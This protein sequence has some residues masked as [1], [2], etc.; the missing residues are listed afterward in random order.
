MFSCFRR[1]SKAG[2]L[3]LG[4]IGYIL[5]IYTIMWEG[6]KR[7]LGGDDSNTF[8]ID[9]VWPSRTCR[10][11][12]LGEPANPS[13]RLHI[14]ISLNSVEKETTLMLPIGSKITSETLWIGTFIFAVIDAVFIP[15][16][17]WRIKTAAFRPIKWLLVV[18]AGIF[19]SILWTWGLVT[20]WD[21]VYHYIFPTWTH[22]W[23]PPTFGLL[24]AGICLLFW[25]LAVRLRGNAVVTFCL[26]GGLWGM[27]MHLFAVSIG[28]VSKPPVLRGAAP[29]AAVIFAIFEFMLYWCIILT[30][31]QLLHHSWRVWRHEST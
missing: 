24:Y 2:L 5:N 29:A 11:P 23:I 12:L 9:R 21:S 8:I 18:T 4:K 27:I 19:W 31:A 6:H 15:I 1:A 10:F 25:W 28:I 17:A 20:F 26:L 22:W 7:R 13:G 30:V 16:L 3:F 14:R